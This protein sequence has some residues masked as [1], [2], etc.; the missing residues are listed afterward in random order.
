MSRR[1]LFRIILSVVVV[2]FGLL[3]L[4]GVLFAQGPGNQGLQRAIEV[5]QK[6]TD[7]LRH[8]QDAQVMIEAKTWE[9]L[10]PQKMPYE[11][12]V[13]A[14]IHLARDIIVALTFGDLRYAEAEVAW[15]EKLLINYNMPQNCS[16]V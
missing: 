1:I 4:P 7:A 10:K 16:D 8:Y 14:N 6:Y 13:N 9:M 11:H 3:A 15:V 5:Q 12:F 2:V